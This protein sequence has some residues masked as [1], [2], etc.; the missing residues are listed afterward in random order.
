M[1]PRA[2]LT[3]PPKHKHA[4]APSAN[5]DVGLARVLAARPFLGPLWALPRACVPLAD[6]SGCVLRSP[7]PPNTTRSAKSEIGIQVGY[8]ISDVVS[9]CIVGLMVTY[10]AKVRSFADGENTP[11]IN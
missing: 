6:T 2:R 3:P 5:F 8:S 1:S 10:I 11:L 9:K 4:S 7:P